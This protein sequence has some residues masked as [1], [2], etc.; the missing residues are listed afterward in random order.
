MNNYNLSFI[1]NQDLF[2][3]V[4]E[5]VEKY[6]FK[7]SSDE[8][9]SNIVDPIK[10]TFDAKIYNKNIA[11]LIDN[12]IIRQIDK[13][14]NN[15]IGYFHQN[16]F[17][18]INSDWVVL[19]NGF[20]IIN[21]KEKIYVELKNKHNTMNSSSSQK[22]YMKMQNQILEDHESQCFL[23]EV[24]A[25]KSQNEKWQISLD[26]KHISHENIRRVSIDKFYERV[27]SI[28][29]AFKM[30]LEVLPEVLDDV[31]IDMKRNGI[32]STILSDLQTKEKNI[33]KHLYLKAFSTYNGFDDFNIKI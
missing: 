17:N 31:L 19:K 2:N 29:G 23:V 4:K 25:K 8:F 18:Y 30:L 21:E 14:N 7:I 28:K 16:I 6:K 13:S 27:T 33:L 26:G 20:D 24:I 3:H 10:L 11:E 12:E 9:H 1:K 32:E 22:T 5:L 15:H